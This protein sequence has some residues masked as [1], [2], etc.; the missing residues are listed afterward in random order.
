MHDRA[1]KTQPLWVAYFAPPAT[2][3][4]AM[5]ALGTLAGPFGA[6]IMFLA[7]SFLI[8]SAVAIFAIAFLARRRRMDIK[9]DYDKRLAW[10]FVL[11]WL[12]ALAC[13]TGTAT[14]LNVALAG[15]AQS[16]LSPFW[17]WMYLQAP[18]AA[19][20]AVLGVILDLRW[21]RQDRAASRRSS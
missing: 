7:A 6:S 19:L 4:G 2:V 3:A 9:V 8:V 17:T 13:G 20:G 11:G 15:N 5:L 12:G 16:S 14:V 10:S 1:G 18:F 21:N